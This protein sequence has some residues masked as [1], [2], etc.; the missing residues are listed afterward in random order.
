MRTL[1]L[2]PVGLAVRVHPR[3]LVTVI[4]LGVVTVALFVFAVGTGDYPIPPGKV[5]ETLLG[6]GDAGTSFVVETLRLPRAVTA[7]LV[8]ASLGVAGAIFQS[9]TRNPLGSPDIIGFTAGASTAAVFAIVAL[10]ADTYTISLSALGGGLL[11]AFVVYLLAYR[12][13][14]QGYRLVLV[15]IALSTMLYGLRDYL[16]T[17]ARLEDAYEASIWIQGSL[18]GRGWEHARPLAFTLLALLPALVVLSR[19]LSI[20]EMG[21]DAAKALGVAVERS[22]LWLVLVGVTL[23]AVAT[24]AAGPIAF[25]ALA[26]PQIARRITRASGPGLGA[27]ALMGSAL[28]LGADLLTQRSF[29][30]DLP[31]GITTGV[32]GGFYLIWMLSREWK[33]G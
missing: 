19:P 3:T 29:S 16:L 23:T 10:S 1:Q 28:L 8:G 24:A 20:L 27:A 14:V 13:G 15:G 25:V 32:L 21:D 7:V 17:R 5:I 33:K 11:T 12:G 4:A 30:F 26:A 18:N 6:G 22:R 31:V 2:R 9:I